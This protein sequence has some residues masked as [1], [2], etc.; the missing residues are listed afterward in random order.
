MKKYIFAINLLALIILISSCEDIVDADNS[1]LKTKKIV[2][3][4]VKQDQEKDVI[5][6]LKV[7]NLWVYRVTEL[8]DEGAEDYIH[9]DTIIVK[10]EVTINGEKWF[11]V[12]NGFAEDPSPHYL[13]NTDVGLYFK[14]SDESNESHLLEAYPL[15]NSTYYNGNQAYSI[16]YNDPTKYFIDTLDYW[17]DAEIINS[18]PMVYG[19]FKTYKYYIWAKFRKQNIKIDPDCIEYY[20][21]NIGMVHREGYYYNANKEMKLQRIS[22]LVY[23]NLKIGK[24]V[25]QSVYEIDFGTLASGQT[26]TK[27][28]NNL[29]ENDSDQ[30]WIIKLIEIDNDPSFTIVNPS[31]VPFTVAP[32]G[33]FRITVKFQPSAQGEYKS[34][35][36]FY[37]EDNTLFTVKLKGKC[38]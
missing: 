23:T 3:K 15:N 16:L 31:T 9:Y 11:L 27:T 24:P 19:D 21:P 10:K 28:I 14:D 22:E 25:K 26:A 38:E 37:I 1:I 5:M 4:T 20:V 12:S 33:S 35:L 2:Y 29:F 13:T 34:D 30:N 8:T 17:T 6:P 7:D 36:L 32:G 18:Y